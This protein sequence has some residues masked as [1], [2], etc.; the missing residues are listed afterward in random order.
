M[1]KLKQKVLTHRNLSRQKRARG[2]F[3]LLS[4]ADKQS[5]RNEMI[6]KQ[7]DKPEILPHRPGIVHKVESLVY[8]KGAFTR[9]KGKDIEIWRGGKAVLGRG[10]NRK[11]HPRWYDDRKKYP[12]TGSF[13]KK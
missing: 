6:L 11:A 4:K 7:H 13:F 1:G 9:G 10:V 3:K 12:K 2:L 5:T 8:Q